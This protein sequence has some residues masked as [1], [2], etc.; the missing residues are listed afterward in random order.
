MGAYNVCSG[1]SASVRELVELA[2]RAASVPVR[3]DVDEGRVR[4]HDVPEIRGSPERLSGITDWAP[5]IPLERTLADAVAAWRA[6]LGA[7]RD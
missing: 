4:G 6:E 5:E 7:R 1:R 3:H 2:A